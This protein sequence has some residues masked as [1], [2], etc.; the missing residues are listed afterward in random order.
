[1]KTK[2]RTRIK[3]LKDRLNEID[4]L[5][6]AKH[7]DIQRMRIESAKIAKELSDVELQELNP[8]GK[9]YVTDDL[10]SFETDGYRLFLALGIDARYARVTGLEISWSSNCAGPGV[11][12]STD[13]D[14]DYAF[15]ALAACE[16]A[17][18]GL[19]DEALAAIQE[20]LDAA[21]RLHENS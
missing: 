7:S 14:I 2:T 13:N 21:K 12:T 6:D 4:S 8:L 16:E 5:C 1:M 10:A 17:A 3:E 9:V 20:Q 18:P 19:F 11:I 15:A